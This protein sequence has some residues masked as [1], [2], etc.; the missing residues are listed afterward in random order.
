[1]SHVAHHKK[2]TCKQLQRLSWTPGLVGGTCQAVR[3]HL[4]TTGGSWKPPVL[5]G[6]R[7]VEAQHC[8][9]ENR[10]ESTGVCARMCVCFYCVDPDCDKQRQRQLMPATQ[11]LPQNSRGRQLP[12]GQL[13]RLLPR[14]PHVSTTEYLTSATSWQRQRRQI[15]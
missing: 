4:P 7:R 8:L 15:R 5:E 2:V 3:S 13:L 1:M 6:P 9:Y 12:G 11:E 14:P 10:Y